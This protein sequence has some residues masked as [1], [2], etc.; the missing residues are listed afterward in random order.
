[1]NNDFLDVPKMICLSQQEVSLL[2]SLIAG[3]RR[4]CHRLSKSIPNGPTS[5]LLLPD[6]CILPSRFRKQL[7]CEGPVI[8]VEIKPK[9]GFLPSPESLPQDMLVK[10]KVSR[11]CLKQFHKLKKGRVSVLSK[12]CPLDL[13]SGCLQRQRR[14]I[15]SLLET[16]QNN[17]RIFRDLKLVY[18]EDQRSHLNHVLR[19]V[20]SIDKPLTSLDDG[21][22]ANLNDNGNGSTLQSRRSFVNVILEALNRSARDETTA[23]DDMTTM[24]KRYVNIEE[25]FCQLHTSCTEAEGDIKFKEGGEEGKLEETRCNCQHH[26]LDTLSVLGSVFSAQ[27]LDSV[28]SYRALEMARFLHK[29]HPSL[30]MELKTSRVDA[31]GSPT[32][33]PHESL[34]DFY[35]RKVW[36]FIVSLTAKD[37]S[38]MIALQRIRYCDSMVDEEEII[39]EIEEIDS[40]DEKDD[41]GIDM[42][43][44][45]RSSSDCYS[46]NRSE[47]K[48]LLS[49]ARK[50]ED[51]FSFNHR[52]AQI[53]HDDET[54]KS[55]VVSVSI[56][57]LDPKLPNTYPDLERKI[58]EKDSLMI[59]SFSEFLNNNN[60]P[61]N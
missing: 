6:Y 12:Y 30:M 15:E 31:I 54:S 3:S 50:M 9:Q 7:L 42:S 37:C 22:C 48:D 28:D 23:R 47:S 14:A 26:V 1:M 20:F 52:N 46:Q 44:T 17:L 16:P 56:T 40:F 2:N 4:P 61:N 10:S 38:I 59:A 25:A 34:E 13:F 33:L 29:K 43:T 32:R 36:E 53:I 41:N 11:F 45:G 18:G 27:R 51:N 39:D 5:A 57:D 24:R 19:G 58:Q 60:T 55:Y 21:N 35:F 49:G 8:C